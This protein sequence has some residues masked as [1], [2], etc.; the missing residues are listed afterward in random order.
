MQSTLLSEEMANC[1]SSEHNLN[2]GLTPYG[3]LPIRILLL[4]TSIIQ[5]ANTPSR[6]RATLSAPADAYK[7]IITSTSHLV[8]YSK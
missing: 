2:S 3:S 6:D 8:V 5:N 7:C 1:P 4:T